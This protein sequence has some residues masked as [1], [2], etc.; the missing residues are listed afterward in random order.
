MYNYISLSLNYWA[1]LS[2]FPIDFLTFKVLDYI[3]GGSSVCDISEMSKSFP[4]L[5]WFSM[6]KSF[7]IENLEGILL[8]R[9]M[10]PPIEK[11]DL[12]DLINLFV[13]VLL[14]LGFS[15]LSS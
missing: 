13:R 14:S 1:I 5:T 6:S 4:A 9:S 15:K 7:S 3:T 12:P 2:R 8:V 10:E 11:D